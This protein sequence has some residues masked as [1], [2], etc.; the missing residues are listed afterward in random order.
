MLTHPKSTMRLLH[1]LLHLTSGHVTLYQ[2]NFTPP[3]GLTAP[4]GLT[5]GSASYFYFL[6]FLEVTV[7]NVGD[8]FL[9]HSV[10]DSSKMMTSL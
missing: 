9:R 8:F 1:I 4:G 2:V 6:V 10:V 5:L 7:E 3:I